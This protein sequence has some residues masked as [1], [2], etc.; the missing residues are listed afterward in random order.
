MLGDEGWHRGVDAIA[1]VGGPDAL[2]EEV[3]PERVKK[4]VADEPV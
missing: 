1:D 4:I 2:P 3:F